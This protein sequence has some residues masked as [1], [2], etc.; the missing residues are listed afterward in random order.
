VRIAY[1]AAK[2]FSFSTLLQACITTGTA[3]LNKC[4]SFSIHCSY[5]KT[6]KISKFQ[7]QVLAYIAPKFQIVSTYIAPT[8]QQVSAHEFQQVTAQVRS[9]YAAT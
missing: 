7:Q 6:N 9:G 5:I 2:Q 3:F 1:T 4:A 8:F